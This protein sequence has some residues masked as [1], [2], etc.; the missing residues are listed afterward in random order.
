M[1]LHGSTN[2]GEVSPDGS[3]DDNVFDIMQ[4][5]ALVLMIKTSNNQA[6]ATV[7]KSETYGRRAKKYSELADGLHGAL[8]GHEIEVVEP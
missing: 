6:A 4:G 7:I 1:D 8:A 2:K 5:V 3:A